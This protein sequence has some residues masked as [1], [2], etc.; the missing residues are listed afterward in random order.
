MS[1]GAIVAVVVIG[2]VVAF[3]VSVRLEVAQQ[4]RAVE[5][6]RARLATAKVLRRAEGASVVVIQQVGSSIRQ[7]PRKATCTLTADGLTCL[8]DDGRWGARARFAPGAPVIGDV[9]LGGAPALIKGGA[10]AGGEVP[11]WL[12]AALPSL[13]PDGVILQLQIGLTW[14]VAVPEP[15]AW[16][17]DLTRVAGSPATA[18]PSSGATS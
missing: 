7:V 11:G 12:A 6:A 3:L 18:A 5:T 2:L 10:A 15:E 4:R 17:A 13:P 9:A 16:F 8:S 14:L 1:L